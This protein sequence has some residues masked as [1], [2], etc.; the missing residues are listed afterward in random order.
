MRDTLAEAN[1]LKDKE[2]VQVVLGLLQTLLEGWRGIVSNQTTEH[3]ATPAE[4]LAPPTQPLG[5]SMVG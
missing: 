4:P 1:I 2:K 3:D 5:L